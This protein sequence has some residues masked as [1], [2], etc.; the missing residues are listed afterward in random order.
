MTK[1]FLEVKQNSEC[2]RSP[3]FKERHPKFRKS[4]SPDYLL[5]ADHTRT[6]KLARQSALSETSKGN[7]SAST[8]SRGRNSTV[9]SIDVAADNMTNSAKISHLVSSVKHDPTISQVSSS[10]IIT[11]RHQV[12]TGSYEKLYHKGLETARPCIPESDYKTTKQ[13]PLQ[14]DEEEPEGPTNF[15]IKKRPESP[16]PLPPY[17]FLPKSTMGFTAVSSGQIT[18]PNP[19]IM[20]S[21][22]ALASQQLVS[23]VP[24]PSYSAATA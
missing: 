7:G 8:N 14:E 13:D 9:S 19:F 2:E 21:I 22:L 10:N 5:I 20:Q 23:S 6:I 16:P 4:S 17:R 3:S 12:Y 1:Y 24:P 18:N 11:S 15:S